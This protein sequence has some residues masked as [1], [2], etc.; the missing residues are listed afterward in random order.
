MDVEKLFNIAK[1]LLNRCSKCIIY[2]VIRECSCL[3]LT[4]GNY[5][6]ITSINVL[7]SESP[8]ACINLVALFRP[9]LYTMM[10]PDVTNGTARPNVYFLVRFKSS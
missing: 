4:E 1:D 7:W 3:K 5:P 6:S 9:T 8:R 2:N 10:Y